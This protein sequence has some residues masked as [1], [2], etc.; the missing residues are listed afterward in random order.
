MSGTSGSN[1]EKCHVIQMVKL[2]LLARLG[3]CRG[4]L[5]PQQAAGDTNL[6]AVTSVSSDPH[7][8]QFVWLPK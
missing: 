2:M 4:V 8:P 3:H 6:G 1:N 5:I 7:H